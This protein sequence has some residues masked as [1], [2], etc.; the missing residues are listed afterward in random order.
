MVTTV[1][2]SISAIEEAGK[3]F[4]YFDLDRIAKKKGR[5]D[6]RNKQKVL[7]RHFDDLFLFEA[8]MH[9][10]TDCEN[11]LRVTGQTELLDQLLQMSQCERLQTAILGHAG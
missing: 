3:L 2:L 6:H 8:L 1:A 4:L 9:L 7:A 10:V 11:H 5:A